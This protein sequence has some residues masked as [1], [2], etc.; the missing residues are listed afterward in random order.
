MTDE[1]IEN[2]TTATAE[3]GGSY[4]RDFIRVL[5]V[6]DTYFPAWDGPTM[7]VSNYAK[8]MV[9]RDDTDVELMVPKYP[10]YEDSAEFPVHRIKSV[11]A[12]EKYRSAVPFLQRKSVKIIARKDKPFDII[13]A[14]SPF[15]LGR[16]AI[17]TGKK[18]GIPTVITLHTR[19]HEDFDRLLKSKALRRFMMKFILKTFNAADY[20]VCVSDGTVDTLKQYGY[21]GEA[22]VIRNGTELVY[23]ANAEELK[24]KVIA[25]ENLGNEENVF[26][27][28]G[29]IV[30]NKKL[31]LALSAL[32]IL[33]D[34]GVSFRYLIVGAG[35]YENKLKKRVTEL[36]L[37]DC[38]RFTGKIM[39][40]SLLS[41]YYLA[42][43]LFLFP[44]TFDTASLAPIEAAALK[45]PSLMTRGCSTAEIITENRNGY[46]AD[47]NPAAW[48]DKIKEIIADKD[49]LAAAKENA[50]KE[51][52]RTW[53]SVVD[54]VR[55]F[56]A[57]AI[58][59]YKAKNIKRKR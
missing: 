43:D 24:Q 30:E 52:Y 19:F 56:Y 41:G 40:R 15:L 54:E 51:V 6:L 22:R 58:A 18:Y 44:S 28:V 5:E 7:L 1:R 17:K 10:H 31:D 59:T 45:L 26:L 2:Y 57:E 47:E 36:G 48:A 11:P 32:K 53:D 50:Y 33:K 14:H 13:H 42:S 20:V 35:S 23:P 55:G 12:Q 27:S 9:K 8:C 37:D 3:G 4:N 38:V 39:D 49:A 29:R 46:L 25:A 16:H 34:E 21:K